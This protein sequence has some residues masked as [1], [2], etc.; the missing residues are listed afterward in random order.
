M[1]HKVASLKSLSTLLQEPF[2][3]GVRCHAFLRLTCLLVAGVFLCAYPALSYDVLCHNGNTAFEAEFHS[4]V[5]VKIGPPSQ[6]ELAIRSC[7]AILSWD[8]HDL[9]VANNAAEIDLDMFGVE[10]GTG[11]AVVAFQ[12]KQ[13]E[14]ECCMRYL[15][16]SLQKP[17]QLLRTIVGARYFSAAD[18]NLDGQVEIWTDDAAAVDG[19]EGLRASQLEFPP[20]CVLRFEDGRLVDVSSEFASHFDRTIAKL[21]AEINPQELRIFKS[22]DGHLSAPASPTGS[23]RSE[24]APLLHVKE[25]I[26][27]LVWA[28]LYSG[29]DKQAWQTLSEMW[30]PGDVERIRSALVERRAHGMRAQVDDVSRA[31]PSLDVQPSKVYEW[32]EHPARPIMVRFYPSAGTDNMRGKIRVNA[33]VDSVGKVW[34]VKVSSRDKAV[35]NS[36]Q[37]S[38]ANWKFIPAFVDEHPV[39]SRVRMTVSVEQ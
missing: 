2:P 12:V 1:L 6:G 5:L 36:V 35:R 7:R 34:W 15:I 10:V 39:A 28:Y 3:T 24:S 14:S 32:P 22:G 30:P 19:F 11:E 18:T 20:V 16:Y 27:E 21:R 25:Q 23:Q 17:P 33:V 13:A 9:V 37:R 4:R 26:L 38:A 29:R 31:H 8:T